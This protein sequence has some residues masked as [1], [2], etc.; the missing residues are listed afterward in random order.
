M[1]KRLSRHLTLSIGII[2]RFTTGVNT[3]NE[4]YLVGVRELKL[5]AQEV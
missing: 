1:F 2:I 5:V 3:L 4:T